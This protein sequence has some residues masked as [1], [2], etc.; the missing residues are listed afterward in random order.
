MSDG[1]AVVDAS[2]LVRVLTSSDEIATAVKTFLRGKA[3]YAPTLVDYEVTSAL[4]GLSRK[5]QEIEQAAGAYLRYLAAMP[6]R[7]ESAQPLVERV[8]SLRHNYTVYDASYVALAEALDAT[9]VTCDEK[10]ERAG[11]ARCSIETIN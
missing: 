7:R 9:L 8:W 11:V 2:C 6:I 5:R 4:R 1:L 10:F 3:L